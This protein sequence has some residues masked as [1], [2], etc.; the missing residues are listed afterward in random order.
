MREHRGIDAQ[1]AWDNAEVFERR[2]QHGERRIAALT[3]ELILKSEQLDL[4][5]RR[6]YEVQELRIEEERLKVVLQMAGATAA[7]LNQPLAELLERSAALEVTATCGD[8]LREKITELKACAGRVQQIIDRIQEAHATLLSPIAGAPVAEAPHGMYRVLLLEDDDEFAASLY[9]LLQPWF[10][11]LELKRVTRCDAAEKRLLSEPYDLILSD[12]QLPDG[13]SLDLF[14]RLISQMVLPPFILIS[15]QGSED[16]VAQAVRR[17]ACDYLPRSG[18]NRDRLIQSILAALERVRLQRELQSAHEHLA[19]LATHDELTGLHNRRYLVD[20]LDVEI[21]RARRYH[22]PLT[23]CMF[24]L[25]HF[26]DVNDKYGHDAGDA[27]LVTVAEIL[28][29]TVR[30]PDIAGRYGGEEFLIVLINTGIHEAEHFSN[31]LRE[32]IGQKGFRVQEKRDVQITC[33]IGLSEFKPDEDESASLIHRADMAMYQ[34]KL[35]GRNQ[36]SCQG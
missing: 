3:Q 24:D 27:V 13:T 7:E 4:T 12:F 32:K 35:Q 1:D 33:S 22:Q 36:V 31:R 26:K 29:H 21:A 2:L 20:A 10:D 18:L 17:G 11:I 28:R 30:S 23:L 9:A 34:A 25:D 19:E 14:T 6:M 16:I 5:K 15:G 8:G